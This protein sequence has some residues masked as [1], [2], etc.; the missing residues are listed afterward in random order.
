M[1]HR[2]LHHFS[3]LFSLV[4]DTSI[5]YIIRMLSVKKLPVEIIRDIRC[6]WSIY[7]SMK[8]TELQTKECPFCGE[9]IQSRAIK[10]RYCAEFLNTPQ[11][12]A[13]EAAN[14]T[15]TQSAVGERRQ[16]DVLFSAKPSLW[17]MATTI[18]K[19][20]IVAALAIFLVKFP[21]EVLVNEILNLKLS[22]EQLVTF[23]RYRAVGGTGIAIVVLLAV[24]LKAVKLKTVYYEVTSDRIE[25][26]RG[27][28]DRKVDNL[29]MF[30]VTD[31]KLRRSL[32]DCLVGVGTVVLITMDKSDPEFV[33]EKVHN[34]RQLY[35]AI[36]K[37]S[38]DAD[39][40]QRVVHLE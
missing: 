33:F 32:L 12:K 34:P 1:E 15:D 14:Q 39:Q 30:R 6:L 28:F 24:L 26:G 37:A 7:I 16:G 40:K 2:I 27:I 25:W 18:A 5:V 11:A 22:E 29:D 9:T 4:K 36:K 3:C 17:A 21:L 35:D 20:L 31:L 10:C 13:M 8:V 19:G 23:A 38:L